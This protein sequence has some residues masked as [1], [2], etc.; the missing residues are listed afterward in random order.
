MDTS[1]AYALDAATDENAGHAVG[2]AT[3][4]GPNGESRE[5]ESKTDG[6][7]DNITDGAY[8]RHSNRV[9]EE[10]GCTNPKGLAGCSANILS[11]CLLIIII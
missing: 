9:H 11:D 4:Y 7:A 2:S 5:G 6:P 3:Y 1:T 8:H 10:V